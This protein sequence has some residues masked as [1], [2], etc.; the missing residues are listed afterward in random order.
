MYVECNTVAISCNHCCSGKSNKNYVV[1]ECVC[2]VALRIQHAVHMR[3]IAIC[4]LPQS[5]IFFHI[6][7]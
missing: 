3:H 4:G 5:T 6:I 1:R 2:T 7:S